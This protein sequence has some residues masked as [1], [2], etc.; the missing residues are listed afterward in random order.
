MDEQTEMARQIAALRRTA[1]VLVPILIGMV[2]TLIGL[3]LGYSAAFSATVGLVTGL[4]L[5]VFARTR[6]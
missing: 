2:F 4:L 5:L 1:A 3:Q 6:G